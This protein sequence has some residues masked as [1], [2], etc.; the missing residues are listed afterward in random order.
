M[1]LASRWSG[2]AAVRCS[3]GD[4]WHCLPSQN[5]V[6]LASADFV[7]WLLEDGGVH[8]KYYEVLPCNS[9]AFIYIAMIHLILKRRT[10]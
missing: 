1:S 2:S 6:S 10:N 4:Q 5:R 9:E 7:V 3:F 8:A